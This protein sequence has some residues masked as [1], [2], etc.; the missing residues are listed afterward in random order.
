MLLRLRPY[1][2]MAHHHDMRLGIELL[3][4]F[5]GTSPIAMFFVFATWA[6]CNS[7]GSRTSRTTIFSPSSSFFFSSSG[8]IS[9]SKC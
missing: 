7:H 6:V 2:M 9:K 1:A 4:R 3:V 5:C 8:V